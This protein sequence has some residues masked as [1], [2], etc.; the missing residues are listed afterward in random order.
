MKINFYKIVSDT[1]V[2]HYLSSIAEDALTQHPH[3]KKLI[4]QDL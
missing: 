2:S 1:F 4:N 3:I